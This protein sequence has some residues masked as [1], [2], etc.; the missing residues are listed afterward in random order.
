MTIFDTFEELSRER[1]GYVESARRNGLEEG[2]RRLLSDL[3]PDNAHFIYELLQNAEDAGAREITFDL[4]DNGLRVE[5]D[6]AR[7]FDLA[8]IESITG[9]GASTKA[10][11]AT[12]IGKFGVGFKAVFAYTQTPTIHSGIHSFQIHD[13][14]V[15][16][17]IPPDTEPGIT[18]FWFPFDRVDKPAHLAY[19]EVARALRDISHSTLLF[20]TNIRRIKSCMPD[21]EPRL[22]ERRAI[23][24]NIIKIESS[25]D[26]QPSYW[27]RITASTQVEEKILPVAAAFALDPHEGRRK[28]SDEPSGFSVKPIQ[29]QVFIYFPAVKETSGLKFHIHA[30]FAS[31]V[32]RDSVRDDPGNDHLIACIAQHLVEALPSMRDAGLITDGLLQA[33]PN[34]SDDLPSRYAPVQERVFKAFEMS[35]LTPTADSRNAP[36]R[37]LLRAEPAIRRSFT[38][39]DANLLLGIQGLAKPA[40]GWLP[41][42]EGRSKAF[43]DSLNAISFGRDVLKTILERV[44]T[45][46]RQNPAAVVAWKAWLAQMPTSN[47]RQLYAVLGDLAA[48]RSPS[49]PWPDTFGAT[50]A[51]APLIRIHRSDGYDHVIGQDAFLP[52]EKGLTL[53][54]LVPDELAILDDVDT[55][56]DTIGLRRLYEAVGTKRWDATEELSAMFDR[57]HSRPAEVTLEHLS[58]LAQLA[59]LIDDGGIRA[60]DYGDRKIMVALDRDSKRRWT[61][62]RDS[63]LDEPLRSTG[64]ASLYDAGAYVGQKRRPLDPAYSSA[65]FDVVRLAMCLGS[66][67]EP[68]VA[69]IAPWTNPKYDRGW[70]YEAGKSSYGVAR[71]WVIP[72][73][74]V[75]LA[76]GDDALLAGLW[77][78]VTGLDERYAIAEYG[79]NKTSPTHRFDSKLLQDLSSKPWILD[80]DGNLRVPSD[81]TAAEL[82]L[83][84]EMPRESPILK[85]SHFGRS[86]AAADEESQRYDV[87]AVQFGFGSAEQARQFGALAKDHPEVADRLLA[88][89]AAHV[90]PESPS[91]SPQRRGERAAEVA[92]Q[93]THRSYEKRLRSVRVQEPGLRSASKNYLTE[94]YTNADEAML[95]QVCRSV[96]PFKIANEYYFEAVQFDPDSSRDLPEN[97]LALCPTCAAM[98]RYACDTPTSE[99]REDLLTQTVG[100]RGSIEIDVILAG[101]S[102]AIRFVGKHAIDLQAALELDDVSRVD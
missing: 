33:L 11:E 10:D 55:S 39:S 61:S 90:L 71:D 95:C 62:P 96:M 91:S 67:N 75:I 41:S 22:L 100:S 64:L 76:S 18:R 21:D 47:L 53:D 66:A 9:I 97:R 27:Y 42:R 26:D 77:K 85:R 68:E 72:N 99:L 102:T 52:T 14:F 98:Y 8:D 28:D 19:E 59:Q 3:Y 60:D 70:Q 48:Q 12:S 87:V 38:V 84:L 20:L 13:L 56:G 93:A 45:R 46:T 17:A 32:A 43:L 89:A 86:A 78:L 2:F 30:P 50:L 25:A 35:D 31:T 54:R 82:A 24:G 58:E 36:S 1:L 101:S 81:M 37:Q 49:W 34:K 83:G 74:D 57:Y 80:R 69:S 63:Y 4:L 88:E 7:M 51:K 65:G 23:G 79:V 40:I 16:L 44:G 73:L 6:G 92:A 5:H 29:G 15:P 94:L